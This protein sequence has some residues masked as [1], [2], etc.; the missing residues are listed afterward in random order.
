MVPPETAAY[1]NDF[2]TTPSLACPQ[3]PVLLTRTQ[4]QSHFRTCCVDVKCVT[5][6]NFCCL[7]ALLSFFAAKH[8]AAD[9]QRTLFDSSVVVKLVKHM[10]FCGVTA[11]SGS[12]STPISYS[13]VALRSFFAC[14]CGSLPAGFFFH[15]LLLSGV[16]V[17]FSLSLPQPS[18]HTSLKPSIHKGKHPTIPKK[19]KNWRHNS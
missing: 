8:I 3:A 13:W 12:V 2:S 10:G 16:F 17:S 1:P 5:G 11:K 7:V 15:C 4:M 19:T 14:V 9:R 6:T 18:L